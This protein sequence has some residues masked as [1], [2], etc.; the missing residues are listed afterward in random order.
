MFINRTS[1]RTRLLLL[2]GL[3]VLLIVALQGITRL[4]DSK[5]NQSYQSI[6]AAQEAIQTSQHSIDDATSLKD[7]INKVQTGVMDLRL[8]EKTFLQ[9]RLAEDKKKFDQMAEELTGRLNQLQ[10][11]EV[12]RQFQEYRNNFE[13]RASLVLEH[14]ALNAKMME[15]LRDSE[16]R[17]GDILTELGGKQS[18]AQLNGTKLKDDELELLNVVRDCRIVFLKL[19]NLQQQF[20]ATG[21]KKYV[22]QYKQVAATDANWGVSSL[23]EFAT[24]L[25]NTN[26]LAASQAIGGSLN[27]FL[28]DIDHSLTLGIREHQLDQLLASTGVN[29][30]K[31]ADAELAKADEEVGRQKSSGLQATDSAQKARISAD[32]ARRF[33]GNTI[34]VVI[35]IG[36]AIFA[37]SNLV[38]ISSIN[39]SL[40]SAITKLS[41]GAGQTTASAGQ[42][43]ASSQSLAEGANEQAASLEETSASLEEMSSMTKRNAENA[44]QANEIAKRACGTADKGVGDMQTMSLAMEAIKVSSDDIAK[45]IKTIDEIAFQTNILALNAAVEAARAG[46]AGMGFAVVAD[47][48]R[49]LA[50]RCAQ[51]AKET[52]AKIEGSLGKTAQGVEISGKVAAALNDIVSE[53]RRVDEL[54]TE[55]AGASREQTDGIAQVNT[56]VAQMDKVTQSNAANA[57][58]SAAAA[59]ELNGQAELLNQ[60]VAEL[61]QLV[62]GQGEVIPPKAVA[63]ARPTSRVRFL[64]P[65]PAT[66]TSG[67][68][69]GRRHASSASTT[70]TA[71]SRRNEIPMAGEFKDF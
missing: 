68:S 54:V 27:E 45:I 2:G 11:A 7:R 33:A 51:A 35:L 49:N 18:E 66:P 46:E 19:Q 57:E 25:H 58:E 6:N 28:K 15:P 10:L 31:A 17:L 1:I 41:Q 32:T 53:V 21:D 39:G 4:A 60:S 63:S 64:R 9:F 8:V 13:E 26:F 34:L 70:P 3:S 50:Q 71:A 42:V 24:S 29:V 22:D 69:T 23:H 16:Q 52:S 12:S 20:I 44:R 56:A 65:A 38:V 62:G 5:V 43:S 37:G 55:V 40:R 59:Q 36:L 48:V 61:L 14:D 47:E 67:A 30:L